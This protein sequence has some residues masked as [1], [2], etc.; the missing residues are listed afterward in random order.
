MVFF[1]LGLINVFGAGTSDF[2]S[3]FSAS[4]C[5]FSR[6]STT[7]YF[8][9]HLRCYLTFLFSLFGVQRCVLTRRL[10]SSFLSLRFGFRF[11]N[12]GLNLSNLELVVLLFLKPLIC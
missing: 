9:R 12:Q 1:G 10:G 7:S 5:L 4:S 6:R 11:L 2:S 8:S 3:L